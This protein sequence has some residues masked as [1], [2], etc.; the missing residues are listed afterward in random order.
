[1]RQA[2]D[3]VWAAI[4]DSARCRFDY[5]EFRNR[6]SKSG[7]ERVADFILFQIIEGLAENK[8]HE[9]LLSTIR[10][11]LE[12][13]GYPASTDE[14]AALLENK[15]EILSAEVHAAGVALAGFARGQSA[16]ELLE[17]VHKLLS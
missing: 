17:Q 5:D 15:K 11:D 16:P 3:L 13:F 4:T 10:A 12:L 7:D 1:M 2:E 14:L 8:S 6:L 9:E